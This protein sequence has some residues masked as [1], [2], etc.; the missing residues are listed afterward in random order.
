[1]P[2]LAAPVV[3]S[4][5]RWHRHRSGGAGYSNTLGISATQNTYLDLSAA[6]T[7]WLWATKT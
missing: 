6:E 2:A 5:G 3:P 4:W 7:Q 1:V